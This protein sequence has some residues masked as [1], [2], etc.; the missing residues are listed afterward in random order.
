VTPRAPMPAGGTLNPS[1]LLGLVTVAAARR[2]G[3]T[4][5]LGSG[6]AT[7]WL[8]YALAEAGGR[9]VAVEHDP[10]RAEAT[11]ADVQAHGLAGVEV[12]LV[13]L[14]ELTVDGKAVDWYDVDALDGLREIDLLVVDG[15]VAP[16]AEAVAPALHVLGRRLAGAAAVVVDTPAT[17]VPRQSAS[18]LTEQGR[19][20]GRWRTLA[21]PEDNATPPRGTAGSRV[22][23]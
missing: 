17:V 15:S 9:L 22:A 21:Q 12:R 1:D 3:L 10:E 16:A 13:P 20:S 18:G 5:A 19:L 4:V 7:V 11:R 23:G 2:P 14:A 6:P 8:G